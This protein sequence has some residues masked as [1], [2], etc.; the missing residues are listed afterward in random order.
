MIAKSRDSL[1]SAHA[2]VF[3]A[4]ALV[5]GSM[6]GTGVFTSLGYQV[7]E[8]RSGFALILIWVIGGI[9]ALCGAL[10]YAEL[11]A[12]LPRS[13]GEYHLLG[14]AFHPALGFLSGWV[15]AT[16]GFAAPASL[17]AIAFGEYLAKAF[18]ELNAT[19]LAVGVLVASGVVYVTRIEV[20]TGFL[21]LF[22]LV[23]LCLLVVLVIAGFTLVT[24]QQSVFVPRSADARLVLSGPFAV[25]LIYV[26]YAYSGWNA[27]TYIVNDLRNPQRTVPI[28]LFM[29][30]ILVTVLYVAANA[31]FLRSTPM[32]ELSGKIDVGMISATKIFG[33]A[34]GRWMAVAISIGLVSTVAAMTWSG[35]RV[36]QMM[37]EDY[38]MLSV[39]ARTSRHGIPYM[40]VLW[41]TAIALVMLIT[42]SFEVIMVYIQFILILMSL[43]TVSAV[44]WLRW[45]EPKLLRPYRTWGYPITPLLYCAFSI[46]MLI[47]VF[48]VRP[49]ESLLGI[50]TVIIGGVLYIAVRGKGEVARNEGPVLK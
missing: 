11:S 25:S 33:A 7:A 38:P 9:F 29:G 44:F 24:S 2:S 37:G 4:T 48:C 45:K 13:G 39:F 26:M 36:M 27:S 41:Q 46:Y 22:T 3:T 40:A 18:P 28:S 19:G 5:V 32:D 21:N 35:P 50:A 17:A 8:I 43:L 16:V 10:S 47:Y 30:T 14:R 34:G 12:A 1:G 49:K 42:S 6:I 23:K 31:A 20:G 15:S